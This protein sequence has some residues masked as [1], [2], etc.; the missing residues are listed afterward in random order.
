[1]KITWL[2]EKDLFP[3]YEN[4]LIDEINKSGNRSLLLDYD[5]TSTNIV[6][7]LE[8]NINPKEPFIFY[9]SLQLGRRINKLPYYPSIYLTVDNY[10]TY[11]YYGY[12]GNDLLNSD[13]LLISLNDA[14]RNKEKIIPQ[15]N[16]DTNK[17]FLRP[18][19]GFKSFAGQTISIDNFDYDFD[20]LCKSYGGL[21]M[22]TLVMFS[23]VK[24]ID[25]EYRFI[26]VSN[27]IITGSIYFDVENKGTFDPH[28]NKTID[29]TSREYEELMLYTIEQ[30]NKYQPDNAFTIDICRLSNG[31]YKVIEINSLC[32]ASLYGA[33]YNRIVNSMNQLIIDDF[34]DVY[35]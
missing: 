34:N 17:L 31:E 16:N 24:D 25:E 33:D 8:K 27:E 22:E 18:S 6:K 21:D 7:Y 1:M 5:P 10:E 12:F 11:K 15:F 14:I 2:I 20:I 9:G 32:C 28:Y 4:I 29:I 35:L 26:V 13:Y 23:S 30:K 3:E 19:N